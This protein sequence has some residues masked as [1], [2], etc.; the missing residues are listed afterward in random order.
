M[1]NKP[2]LIKRTLWITAIL[3]VFVNLVAMIHAYKFTHFTRNDVEKTKNPSKLSLFDKSK[4]LVLGVD[5]PRPENKAVPS[6]SYSTIRLKSNK[7]IECWSIKTENAKG[8]VIIF[9]GFSGEKSS[10]L[11]KS[12]EFVKLGYNTL[13]VD[14]MG[15]GGS[16][17]KQTTL[18]FYEAEEVKTCYDYISSFGEKNI[19]LFGTS[20]GSVAIMKAVNDYTLKP[21]AIIIECPFASMYKTVCARF[22][23]MHVPSFP[24]A[25]MLVFWGGIQNGFWAFNHNPSEYAKTISCATLL[26]YGEKDQNVSRAEIDEIFQNL[27]GKKSLKTY[28]QAGHENYL[29]KYKSE[30]IRDIN[31]FLEQN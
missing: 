31:E 1:M 26:M 24:A 6:Q 3:F 10:M 5:N 16:E 23:N 19:V 14:F 12:D 18:G 17:G 25:S 21:S 27:K 29:K 20:M 9:H 4:T 8:T 11:D 22:N 30:W 15:S 28:S 7:E 13:L 2:K